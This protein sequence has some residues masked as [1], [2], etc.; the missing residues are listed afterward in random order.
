MIEVRAGPSWGAHCSPAAPLAGRFGRGAQVGA[1]GVMAYL[2][3][4]AAQHEIIDNQMKA[5]LSMEFSKARR[6]SDDAHKVAAPPCSPAPLPAG[7][8]P[9]P[10][11][12]M[13]P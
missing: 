5:F 10:D 12:T 4:I 9:T 11:A 6:G 13:P 8:P 3:T 1:R 7:F 2:Q